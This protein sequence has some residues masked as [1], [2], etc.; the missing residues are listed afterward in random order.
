[1]Y[2]YMTLDPRNLIRF[3]SEGAGGG[4]DSSQ[5][6]NQQQQ[7]N[8]QNNNE[9]N[10]D[11]LDDLFQA[12]NAGS[13]EQEQSQQNQQQNQQQGRERFQAHLDSIDFTRD[14]PEIENPEE[15]G[16][17]LSAGDVSGLNGM[18][19]RVARNVYQQALFS[20][21][22]LIKD[23]LASVR[24]ELSTEMNATFD[25]KSLKQAVRT[26]MPFT[27]DP[28]HGAMTDVLIAKAV[29]KGIRNQSDVVEFVQRAYREKL[30]HVPAEQIGMQ[31]PPRGRAPNGFAGDSGNV[32]L[33]ENAVDNLDWKDILAQ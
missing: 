16:R 8:S 5:Q 7:Q 9:N 20:A 29:E 21:N 23:Q 32:Q 27:N 6:Q 3:E 24:E 28:V 17:Q 2:R 26:A 31:V 15:L 13:G 1:M 11:N 30:T 33:P 12:G 22:Q 25:T 19:G 18:L 4:G 14:L 10:R